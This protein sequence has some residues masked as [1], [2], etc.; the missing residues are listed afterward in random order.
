MPPQGRAF[1]LKPQHERHES[2]WYNVM[3]RK[4]CRRKNNIYIK[5]ISEI[6]S[7]QMADLPRTKTF[8]ICVCG[9]FFNAAIFKIKI[10]RTLSDG[11]AK[12]NF[13]VSL[14]IDP[15]PFQ[16]CFRTMHFRAFKTFKCMLAEFIMWCKLK[17]QDRIE[18]ELFSNLA[19]LFNALVGLRD[20]SFYF[21]EWISISNNKICIAAFREICMAAFWE[22][23]IACSCPISP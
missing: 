11:S 10:Y 15:R 18:P 2:S 6:F 12:F 5:N 19:N 23:C 14:W 22:I 7:F 1:I 9:F 20:F 17:I 16:R 3:V 4:I 13:H 8:M 21:A